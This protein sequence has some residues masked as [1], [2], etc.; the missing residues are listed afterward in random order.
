MSHYDESPINPLPWSV[1]LLSLAM[2]VPELV[3]QAAENGLINIDNAL[4]WRVDAIARWGFWPEW[5]DW[6]VARSL[7]PLDEV[8]RIFTYSFIN[9]GFMGTVFALVFTLALGK[10]VGES[11]SNAAVLVIY[12]GSATVAALVYWLIL[13]D[14]FPLVGGITGAYGLIG[15][16]TF[17]LWLRQVAIGGPQSQAFVLI[18]VLMGIQLIFG[19]FFDTGSGWFADLIAFF[20]G[21][22]LSF[23][24]VPGGF[25]RL[26]GFLR[27]K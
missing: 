10:M 27:S 7:Y 2:V 22:G 5:F 23:L 16:Y 13:N 11:M 19:L 25:K 8:A 21:F 12:L 3:F 20:A 26:L 15:G 6:M 24:V 14:P 18:A 9:T 17:L 1:M 4:G